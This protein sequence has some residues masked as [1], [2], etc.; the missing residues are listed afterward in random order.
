MAYH[1]LLLGVTMR[2]KWKCLTESLL[3]KQNWEHSAARGPK[4]KPRIWS[5]WREQVVRGI[6][7]GWG[8]VTEKALI[9]R[10]LAQVRKQLGYNLLDTLLLQSRCLRHWQQKAILWI[11]YQRATIEML[12][13]ATP[14]T[15]KCSW[16][17]TNWTSKQKQNLGCFQIS[18]LLKCC[19]NIK[20][21][22]AI[23]W[24]VC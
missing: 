22:H 3:S 14:F 8:Q 2:I 16:K 9:L 21:K 12:W 11:A 7:K 1:C 24:S 19:S 4:P 13:A 20:E 10:H 5:L 23:P 6:W 18:F 17:P 15:L